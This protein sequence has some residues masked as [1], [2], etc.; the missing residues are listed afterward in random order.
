M[1]RLHGRQIGGFK[2]PDDTGGAVLQ[3]DVGVQVVGGHRAA[4]LR[5]SG[6]L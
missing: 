2:E 1:Q 5:P 3:E 4:P 6:S